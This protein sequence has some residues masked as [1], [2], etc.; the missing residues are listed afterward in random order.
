MLKYYLR[1]LGIG[2]VVTTLILTVVFRLK[3]KPSD[4]EIKER[5]S[6]LGMVM[7]ETTP[8]SIFD[9][10][11]SDDENG[12]KAVSKETTAAGDEKLPTEKQTP[13]PTAE[14]QTPEPDT[15]AQTPEQ[16]TEEPPAPTEKEP[17]TD[18]PV[19]VNTAVIEIVSGM[20]SEAVSRRLSEAGIIPSAA[21]FN[22]YLENNGYSERIRVGTFSVSSDMS[23][24]QLARLI[25][26]N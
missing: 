13:E 7:A 9:K 20:Y 26:G 16:T 6:K 10:T 3:G 15:E 12:T 23:Y 2:I 5:A 17:E 21:D 8:D 18:P 4:S 1:G 19:P 11:T 25:T 24:E 22:L 14:K